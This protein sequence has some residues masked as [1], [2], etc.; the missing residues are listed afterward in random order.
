LDIMSYIHWIN[1]TNYVRLGIDSSSHRRRLFIVSHNLKEDKL[2]DIIEFANKHE[3]KINH[4]SKVEMVKFH[5]VMAK[6]Y[7]NSIVG[8]EKERD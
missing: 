6:H 8:W 7:E 3:L 4:E 5:K 1:F 2:K